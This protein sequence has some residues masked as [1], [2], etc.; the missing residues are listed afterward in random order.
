MLFGRRKRLEQLEKAEAKGRSFWTKVLDAQARHRLF[1]AIQDIS[2]GRGYAF[3]S[4]SFIAIAQQLTVRELGLHR[5]SNSPTEDP[6]VDGYQAILDAEESLVFSLI[7]ALMSISWQTRQKFPALDAPTLRDFQQGLPEFETE[8]RT[9]LR[10]HRVNYDLING[11]FVPRESLELHESV[12]VP[13]LTL[14]AGRKGLEGA[15]TAYQQALGELHNG[16][17]DD[18]IT[19]AATA[20][21]ETLVALGCRGNSLGPLASSATNKGVINAYDKK[22]VDWVSADRSTKGDTHNAEPASREDA[23]FTV[24]I[25]GALILRVATGPMR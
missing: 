5:L 13:A 25:V 23:W 21:Q 6:R 18:A 16:S 7:E 17:P 14:L 9:I 22:I 10:E 11:R 2:E 19:D 24:H 20:L 1:Y 15:E 3:S 8:I 12:V 4:V